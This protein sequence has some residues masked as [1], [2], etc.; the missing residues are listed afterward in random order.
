MGE[1]KGQ[2]L[3][4]VLVLSIFGIVATALTTAFTNVSDDV[5]TKIES[6]TEITPA[7]QNNDLLSF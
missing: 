7:A 1:I 5:V 6:S 3:G 2:L 4:I